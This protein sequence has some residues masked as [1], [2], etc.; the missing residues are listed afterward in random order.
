VRCSSCNFDNAAGKKFCI[1][2]GVAFGARCATCGSANPPEAVFCGDCG[3]DLIVPA[4]AEAD[5]HTHNI[6]FDQHAVEG[7]RRHLTVLFCDLVGSTE[8][9]S[10][11]DPEEWREVVAKYHDVAAQAIERFGGH[12]AQYLG[13]GV[14]AY[15]GYPEAH[16]NNAERAARA[17]LAILDAISRLNEHPTHPK[18]SARIGI[19]SGAVVVGAGAGGD[20][21]VFGD[22]P[23]IAARVQAAAEPGTVAITDATHRL[24][25]GLFMVEERGAQALKGI[26]RPVQLYRVVQPSGVRGRL[27]AGAAARGLTTFVGREDELRSL[28]NRW[29]RALDG[30]GQV[31][32][33]IGEAGIGKSR[34]VQRFREQIAETPHTWVEAA[35]GAFFQNTPF[36]AVTEMLRE[37]LAWRG[38]ESAEEQ[39]AQLETRLELAGLKPAKAL[40]LIAP[41]LNLPLQAKYPPSALSPEQQR[42]RLLATLVEWALGAARAQPTVIAIEDLHLADPS[43]LELIQLLVEQG[44]TSRLL[45]LYTARPEFRPEWPLRVH[46]AH[47]VLNRLSDRQAREMIENVASQKELSGE[48]VET[49]LRRATGVP[50]FVEELTRDLLE[51]GEQPMQHQ[52]PATLRDSLMARLDRL[53]SARELAQIGATI[54]RAFSYELLSMVASVSERELEVALDKLVGADLLH[55][56]GSPPEASYVFK[57]ALV[58]DAAYNTLLKSRRREL[59]Q[60]IAHILQEHFSD[61]ATSAP[62]LLAHHCTEAGLI[63]EAVRY[64]RSAGRKAIERTANVEAIAQLSKGLELTTT[65]PAT[66]ERLL[67]EVKLQIALL[68]PLIATKGYTAPEVEKAC[69]RALEQCQQLG[70]VPQLFTVLG[71]LNSIYYNRGDFEISFELAK[72]MLRLAESRRDPVLRVWG[73]YALGFTLASQGLW[74]PARRHLEHS[75]AFYDAR[76]GGTYGFV[77]DPGPS[78]LALLSHVVHTLGYPDQALKKMQQAMALARNL[79]HPF[80]IAW[81]LGSAGELNWRRGEKLAAQELWEERVALCSQQGFQP[82]LASTSLWLAFALVDQGRG[83]DNIAVMHKA[84]CNAMD[85]LTASE[86]LLGLILL[87]LAQSKVGQADQG[88][89]TIDKALDLVNQNKKSGYAVDL[90][91][92]KG[93]IFLMKDARALRKAEQCFRIAIGIAREQRAKT[94]ELAAVLHLARL[95]VSKERGVEARTMLAEIYNWFTEGFDTADLKDAKALLDELSG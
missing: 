19:D 62:E 70:D 69:N 86:K 80:T 73:H 31:A 53:G 44:A 22:T 29:E 38:D 60:R 79:S 45:L 4:K 55:A 14:M 24:V 21:D 68:I 8:I 37:L 23:N 40:P 89:A 46:H 74:K 65:L 64:W 59:H 51:R 82:L 11:L 71:G 83:S 3:A 13:D 78:A 5:E 34:L 15:F 81:V 58:Q 61:T 47:L 63:V 75:I 84:L 95:L 54:G 49:V 94:D 48:T 43:S 1:R 52:I 50:L 7:E 28:M 2:C 93:Q 90:Y 32:L 85:T 30:E 76:K 35:A 17:G 91:L 25:S 18:L 33:I 67:E 57:H 10:R 36:Y 41:L 16:D 27:E 26:E 77:Q 92:V 6:I 66:S 56:R 9:A 87:G 88:I 12:V 39:L 72:R 42:R 20:A